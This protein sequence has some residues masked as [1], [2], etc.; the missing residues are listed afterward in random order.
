MSLF[1]PAKPKPVTVQLDRLESWIRENSGLPLQDSSKRIRQCLT[2]IESERKLLLKALLDQTDY[3]IIQRFHELSGRLK[4]M[5]TS[6]DGLA[7]DVLVLESAASGL[8][9]GQKEIDGPVSTVSVQLLEIK[10]VLESENISEYIDLLKDAKVLLD[11]NSKL[12]SNKA[13]YDRIQSELSELDEK[14]ANYRKRTAIL[15]ARGFKSLENYLNIKEANSKKREE[16]KSRL[17]ELAAEKGIQNTEDS[18][19]Y[20]GGED[21]KMQVLDELEALRAEEEIAK[22]Q[23]MKDTAYR[24]YQEIEY[25]QEHLSKKISLLN[26]RSESL[27]EA[28]EINFQDKKQELEE[29]LSSWIGKEVKI[30]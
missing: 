24:D 25:Q 18:T 3:H 28:D 10:R 22:S 26:A 29:E 27:N 7:R 9:C 14:N 19:S 4:E 16:L 23:M 21:A 8:R 11:M 2:K 13:E 15:I 5:D 6:I 12:Y 17:Q 30:I 20:P 1:P